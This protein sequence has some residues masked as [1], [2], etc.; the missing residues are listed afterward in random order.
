MWLE[1]GIATET[2]WRF[3]LNIEKTLYETGAVSNSEYD[4][5]SKKNKEIFD[6]ITELPGEALILKVRSRLIDEIRATIDAN[7]W[8]HAETARRLDITD[9]KLLRLY[10]GDPLAVNLEEVL[11]MLAALES[12]VEIRVRRLTRVNAK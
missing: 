7:R 4:A 11:C 8:T 12:D 9:R 10:R 6:T 2:P 3:F 5:M 1:S